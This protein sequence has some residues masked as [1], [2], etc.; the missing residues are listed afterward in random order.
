MALFCLG[1][2]S[3]MC[4]GFFR[5]LIIITAIISFLAAVGFSIYI[6]VVQNRH[7]GICYIKGGFAPILIALGFIEAGLAVVIPLFTSI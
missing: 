5:V 2:L 1:Y 7:M 4:I 6:W 3:M